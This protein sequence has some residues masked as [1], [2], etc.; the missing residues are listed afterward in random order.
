M[1][2]AK[3]ISKPR[4]QKRIPGRIKNIDY[5]D[6]KQL[7]RFITERGKIVP[8]RISGASALCQRRL[9]KAIKQARHIGLLPY[10]EETYK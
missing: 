1:N 9:A 8:S 3:M 2:R 4:K 5:K 10:V 6:P 7:R